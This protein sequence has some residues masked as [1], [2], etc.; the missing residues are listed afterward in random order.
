M[1]TATHLKQ[2]MEATHKDLA[3]SDKDTIEKVIESMVS[4]KE[5]FED[6]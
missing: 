6:L 3:P 2:H 5:P 4:N 1:R